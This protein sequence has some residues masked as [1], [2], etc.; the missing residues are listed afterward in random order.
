MLLDRTRTTGTRLRKARLGAIVTA[1]TLLGWMGGR[2][3]GLVSFAMA[4]VAQAAVPP[5]SAPQPA[6]VASAPKTQPAQPAAAP[7]VAARPQVPIQDPQTRGWEE[8]V[9]YRHGETTPD[10]ETARLEYRLGWEWGYLHFAKNLDLDESAT[11]QAVTHANKE[12]LQLYKSFPGTATEQ[13]AAIRTQ[14]D[15]LRALVD[16]LTQAR[17]AE[18]RQ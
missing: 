8:Y 17:L 10:P 16:E 3:P 4:Q 6:Q 12:L 18:G 15:R 11:G 13:E 7:S 1:L 9:G 14:R 5:T 2:M